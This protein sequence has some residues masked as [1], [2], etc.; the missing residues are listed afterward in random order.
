MQHFFQTTAISIGGGDLRGSRALHMI[1]SWK[2]QYRYSLKKDVD[3]WRHSDV[4]HVYFTELRKFFLTPAKTE[5]LCHQ[6]TSFVKRTYWLNFKMILI[7]RYNM[8]FIFPYLMF[9]PASKMHRL[10][11]L[12]GHERRHFSFKMIVDKFCALEQ[13][14]IRIA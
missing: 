5:K 4:P 1:W 11:M 7:P 13:T 9:W 10:R 12:R 3:W 8:V 6:W 2:L 14:F